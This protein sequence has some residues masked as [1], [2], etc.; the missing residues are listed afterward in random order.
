MVYG[1]FPSNNNRLGRSQH[2]M[3]QH[4][5]QVEGKQK[6]MRSAELPENYVENKET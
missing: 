4:E 6:F 1:T 2:Y 3:Q 5:E